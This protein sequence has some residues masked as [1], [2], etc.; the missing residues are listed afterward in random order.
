MLT[1]LLQYEESTNDLYSFYGFL[2]LTKFPSPEKIDID[3]LLL[4]G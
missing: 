2:K 1:G 4:R 3:N